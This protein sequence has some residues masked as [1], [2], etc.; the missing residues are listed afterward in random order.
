MAD[1]DM[2]PR[3]YRDGVRLR[4]ALRRTGA[5][6]AMVLLCAA[7]GHAALRW[8]TAGIERKSAALRAAASAAQSSIARAAGAYEAQL[9]RQRQATLLRALRREHELAVLAQALEGALPARAW[10]TTVT[11]RRT[12]AAAAATADAG[13]AP[14][15][16]DTAVELAGQAAGYEE[17]TDFLARLARMPGVQRVA[18]QSSGANATDGAIDFQAALTLAA[19]ASSSSVPQP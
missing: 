18:L 9:R 7:A 1:I 17:V 8:S 5:A 11:L 6:L 13:A 2:I 4:H 14:Q 15:L 19:T 16:P 3:S 12:V 10:L